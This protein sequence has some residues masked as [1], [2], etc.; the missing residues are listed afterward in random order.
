[1]Q[2]V[3]MVLI[4]LSVEIVELMVLVFV[5]MER[6]DKVVTVKRALLENYVKTFLVLHLLLEVLVK[7]VELLV[8]LMELLVK[9]MDLLV[10]QMVRILTINHLK[11]VHSIS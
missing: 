9:L 7:L 6:Q 10:Q 11:I 2:Q 3:I 1:V 4:V 5:R 8:K